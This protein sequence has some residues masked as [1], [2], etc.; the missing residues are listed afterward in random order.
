MDKIV[1]ENFRC[2]KAHQ[3][4]ELRPLTFLVGENS[5]GKT[6]FLAA[7]RLAADILSPKR[8]PQNVLDFNTEPFILGAYEQ[9]ASYASGRKGRAKSFVIG[10]EKDMGEN[11]GTSTARVIARFVAH[12]GQPVIDEYSL[13]EIRSGVE[14]KAEIDLL[15]G[16]VKMSD[17]E[18]DGETIHSDHVVGAPWWLD[19]FIINF[20]RLVDQ[21]RGAQKNIGHIRRYRRLIDEAYAIAPVRMRPERTYDPKSD[22]PRPEGNHVPVL[23]K[24]LSSDKEKWPAF[25]EFLRTFGRRSGLFKEIQ[26][27]KL[28]H[29]E[30]DPFQILIKIAGALNNL[31]DVGYGVSQVLPILVDSMTRPERLLLMQQPEIHLH[32]KAQA[33]LGSLLGT[34]VIDRKKQLIVETHSDYIIDR[35]CLD[36]RDKLN[37]MRPDQVGILYFQQK[38]N[39]PWV[40][41][42]PL[43]IDQNGNIQGVPKGYREFFL[44]EEARLFKV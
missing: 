39:Q 44:R 42:H 35:I 1:L 40:K 19:E 32:P 25:E 13:K 18:I 5:T 26:L 20:W 4:I 36:I 37:G 38:P 23:L 24:Q 12:Q 41:I 17:V 9:I 21:K 6:S 10:Y 34:I 16:R 3:E 43:S 28:G 11:T 15:N 7:I 30:S 33:E 29:S 31:I 8:G 27:R 2:F 22:I 14:R